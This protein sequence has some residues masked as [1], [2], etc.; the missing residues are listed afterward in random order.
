MLAGEDVQYDELPSFFSDQYDTGLEFF[1]HLGGIAAE[2]DLEPATNG[3]VARWRTHG[4]LVAAAH[5]NQWD[6]S[7]EL[8]ASVADAL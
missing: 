4:R 8:A 1:G 5:V 3:L 6:R 7:A 2:V